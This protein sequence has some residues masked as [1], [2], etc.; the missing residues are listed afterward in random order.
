[1]HSRADST[2]RKYIYAF[3]WWGAW[4]EE[5]CE[6]AIFPIQE[7]RF[8]LYLQHLGEVSASKSAVE[9][10]MNAIS[11]VQQIASLPSMAES[12]FVRATLSGLQRKLAKPKVRKKPITADMLLA[13][14]GSFGPDHT[15]TYIRLGAMA[16]LSVAAFL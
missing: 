6:V 8:A 7:V 2:I 10:A 9:K 1:M 14:V 13:I 16:L 5:R 12:P 15:L 3:Q 4:A 11:W